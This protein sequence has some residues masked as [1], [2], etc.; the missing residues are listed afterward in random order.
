M[1]TPISH[2]IPDCQFQFAMDA[3]NK[4]LCWVLRK[5]QKMSYGDIAL[6]VKKS[7]KGKK[8]VSPSKTAVYNVVKR[9]R[10]KPK[11]RGRPAGSRAT[12]KRQDDTILATFKRLRPPG[13][14]ITARKLRKGLPVSLQHLSLPTIRARLAENQGYTVTE[15]LFLSDP[16]RA[17]RKAL[18]LESAG[19]KGNLGSGNLGASISLSLSL[20]L[21]SSFS[22]IIF[23]LSLPHSL[24]PQGYL[25]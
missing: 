21:F 7:V 12:T 24:A 5:E 8:A 9:W 1:S 22:P 10:L 16:S 19:I 20:F 17:S 13:C 23:P 3:K 2:K 14:G 6:K 25:D 15:K 4:A 11:P 18:H